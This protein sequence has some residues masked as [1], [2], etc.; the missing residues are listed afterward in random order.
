MQSQRDLQKIYTESAEG[1]RRK[2]FNEIRAKQEYSRYIDYVT[3]VTNSSHKT[4]LD[5][6][7]GNGWTS[8][9]FSQIGKKTVGIDLHKDFF[10]P[11]LNENLKFQSESIMQLSFADN[12][13]DIVTTHECLEHV[14]QPQKAL[15]EMSRV[16][17]PGGV[18][19]VV[20]PNLLSI[21]H[22]LRALM[23]YVWK[24][25]PAKRILF[26]DPELAHHPLGNTLPEVVGYFM[27]NL[28][29]ILKLY[30][31][32]KALFAMREP[33]L[34]PPFFSD[35]DACYLLNPL[36]LKNYFESNGFEIIN[37]SGINRSSWLAALPAGTWFAARKKN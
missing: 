7:C 11:S 15:D 33:D 2:H 13:F 35:N 30:L 20:G 23:V 6:G 21:V 9:L 36:D 5:V 1:V 26:R 19:V 14:P 12:S 18:I 16:L 8:F 34:K 22:S 28:F 27:R 29:F 10:E 17:K 32:K 24:N 31:T 37:Y 25:K 3:Q 4:L